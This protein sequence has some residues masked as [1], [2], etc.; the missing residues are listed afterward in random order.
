MIANHAPGTYY[1]SYV[2][3]RMY[4]A[5]LVNPF[6]DPEK[7]DQSYRDVQPYQQSLAFTRSS[8]TNSV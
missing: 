5:V 7:S 6:R 1:I 4:A 8:T 2:R 3:T